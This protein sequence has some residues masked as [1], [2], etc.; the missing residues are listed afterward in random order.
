M[1]RG[2]FEHLAELGLTLAVELPHDLRAVEV[3][4]V[5]SAFSRHGASEKRL[6]GARRAVQQ[7]AFR[8][9]DAEALEDPRVLERQFDDFA[10]PG[11]LALQSA[12]ILVRHV[13][14]ANA[15]DRFPLDDA[16]VG[17]RTDDDR[18]CRNGPHDPEIHRL[19]ERRYAH[20][21]AGEHRHAGQIRE[22]AIGRNHRR[23][24]TNPR[25]RKTD[26]HRLR[27]FD[28]CHSHELL[29]AGAAVAAQRAVDLD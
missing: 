3:N 9:E 24:R 1:Q 14:R 4:E 5:H 18:A 8:R 19:R 11:D 27:V 26:A 16:D 15:W 25:R 22:H 10:H 29:Q 17:A 12:D 20:D 28:R 7:H 13:G 23:R 21:G 6:A 2:F